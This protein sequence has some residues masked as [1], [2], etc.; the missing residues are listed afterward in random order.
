M[1][2]SRFAGYFNALSFNYGGGTGFPPA[3][4]ILTAP[5]ASPIV[6]PGSL[7]LDTGVT[8]TTDGL[9]FFPLNTNAPTLVGSGSNQ[10]TVTPSSVTSP[11]SPV[12]G[13]ATFTGTFTKIHGTGDPLASAT[14]GLQEA[15]D[16]ANS[17]GGGVVV[18]DSAWANAGGTTAIYNAAVIPS[19]T[20]VTKQDNRT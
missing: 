6:N 18:V 13:Q 10:E 3:L 5:N 9:A 12:P 17:V 19:P 20:L 4:I 14:F 11:T 8:V 15:I 2:L 1:S 7:T 16:Y